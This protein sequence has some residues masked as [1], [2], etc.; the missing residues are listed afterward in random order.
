[1][2]IFQSYA[3]VFL[4]LGIAAVIAA[5]LVP[6]VDPLAAWGAAVIAAGIAFLL[7]LF[8]RPRPARRARA[9]LSMAE[10]DMVF[11]EPAPPRRAEPQPPLVGPETDQALRQMLD[12]L[13]R[14]ARS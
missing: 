4:P 14:L 3:P 5:A 7:L 11:D 10:L 6:M 9:P 13:R 1:M 2:R 8:A 12:D